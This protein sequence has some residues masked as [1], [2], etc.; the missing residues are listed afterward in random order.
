[1]HGTI[2]KQAVEWGKKNEIPNIHLYNDW[3]CGAISIYRLEK[4]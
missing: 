2:D 1:M 3:I 4:K